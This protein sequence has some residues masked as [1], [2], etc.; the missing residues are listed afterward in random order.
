MTAARS[1]AAGA[2]LSPSPLSRSERP[3]RAAAAILLLLAGALLLAL[4]SGPAH[5]QTAQTVDNDWALIP[6]G[7]GPGE[8]FRLLFITSTTRAAN[9]ASIG[10]YNSFVQ[11]RADNGHSAIDSFSG[12]FRA[13]ISTP[14][15]DARD[16]TA[17]TGTGVPIY[18]LSGAKVADDYSDFYN[19]D[20][21]SNAAKSESGSGPGSNVVWTGSNSDGTGYDGQEARDVGSVGQ[22][23]WG[24]ADLHGSEISRDH[25]NGNVSYRLYGLSPVI[26]VSHNP[27]KTTGVTVDQI[28]HNSIQVT[29]IKPTAESSTRPI[30]SFGVDTRERNAADN[31][32]TDWTRRITPGAD[33]TSR[34]LQGLPSGTRQQVRVFARAH[35]PGQT[36]E[37]LFGDSDPVEFTT[38]A[39]AAPG[40]PDAPTVG[41][42]ADSTTSLDVS[43]TAPANTGPPITGYDLQ[44][45]A[46]N[47][48]GWTDGPQDV[49]ATS[50]AI[51]GLQAGTEYQVQVRASNAAGDGAW[52]AWRAGETT[53]DNHLPVFGAT[54]YTFTLA[55]NADGG[56]TAVAVGTVSA[57]DADAGHTVTYAIVA[58]NTAGNDFVIGSS[59]GAITYTGSGVNFEATASFTLTVRA[60]D[61]AGGDADVTVT[62][63]VTDDNTEAP[64]AP[65]APAFGTGTSTSIVATWTEPDNAGP[66]ITGYDVEYRRVTTP[67]SAWVDA[68]HSGTERTIAISGLLTGTGY[69]V[70]VRATNAEGTSGWSASGTGT[71]GANHAPEF[72]FP[73]GETSYAFDLA[74][75]ADGSGET[76]V[77]VGT[78]SATDAD[79]GHAV[80]YAIVAGNT[81]G[82]DFVIGSS[83]GAITYTGSGVNFE[84]TASFTLTVR[85]SDGAGGSADATVTVNVVDADE[86]PS[87]PAAPTFG[88]T[89]A[90]T[91]VVRWTE[92]ANT[93]PAITGYG[94][95]YRLAS[96]APDGTWTSRDAGTALRTTLR[97]LTEDERYQVQVRATNAEGE[98]A[99]STSSEVTVVGAPRVSSVGVG[100]A[101]DR[102][103]TYGAG[104]AII[105]TL[106]FTPKVTVTGT[107]RIALIV[108]AT[109]RYAAYA[110]T[111]DF[112]ERSLVNFRYTVEAGDRDVN[113]IGIPA[114]GL[115]LNG[116]AI[117]ARAG[118]AAA[119]LD[120]AAHAAGGGHK[121]DG[122]GAADRTA[123]GLGAA[124]VDGTTL[125]LAFDEA[126]DP[127]SVPGPSAFT[128]TVAGSSRTVNAVSVS[129]SRVTLTLASAV[130]HDQ[131]V[132]AGY[133]KPAADPLQDGTGNAVATFSGQVATNTT[134]SPTGPAITSFAFGADTTPEMGDTFGA[135]ETIEVVLQYEPRVNVTG[136]PRIALD[137]GGATRYA[138]FSSGDSHLTGFGE[139]SLLSFRYTVQ[140]GDRDEDGISVAANSLEL[141]GGTIVA[142]SGGA[143]A[144]RTHA[145]I[146]A[147]ATRKVDGGTLMPPLAPDLSGAEVQVDGQTLTF[148]WHPPA[149]DAARAAVTGYRVERSADG[150]APWTAITPNLAADANPVFSEQ[151]VP[152]G[153]TRHYRVFALS[154]AGDSPASASVTGTVPASGGD[155]GGGEPGTTPPSGGGSGT[156]PPSGGG[157]S[158]GGGS[159]SG[160]GGGSSATVRILHAEPV[161]EGLPARFRITL[162]APARRRLDLL[163]STTPGTASE[164]ADY[165]GLR[166]RPVT[167]A[168]GESALWLEVATRRDGEAED[169]ETFTV[170][171]SVAPGSAPARVV[172]HEA[173]G[174]IL[175]GPPPTAAVPLLLSASDPAGRQGFVRVVNHSNA[176]G[177]VTV[178]ALDDAG[179]DYGPVT[180]PIAARGSF[181]F[182]TNDLEGGNEAKGLTGSTGAGTGHWRLQLTSGVDIEA[183]AYARHAD[184]FLTALHDAARGTSARLATFNPGSNYRQVS[185]LRLS[186]RGS[187]PLAV[188]VT[189][190]DDAGSA[191]GGAVTVD[192][193]SSAAA[194]HAADALEA[195]TGA[196]TAGSLGDGDGKWRLR[197]GA[198]A[199]FTL[200]GFM[201]SP[202]GHLTNLTSAP[203]EPADG[204]VVVPL[205]LSAADPQGRQGFLRVVNRS[206]GAGTVRIQA[207]DDSGMAYEPLELALDAGAAVQFNADDLELGNAAKGLAG[208]TGP[209]HTGHWWLAVT[210]DLDYAVLAYARHSDG[211]LT[212]LHDAAPAWDGAHRVATFNPGSNWR[213]VSRLRLL[214]TGSEDLALRVRGIDDAGAPSA[215]TV[216]V[217]VPTRRS[218]TLDAAALEAGGEGFEGSLGDGA[219]KWRLVVE[220]DGGAGAL[221]AMSLMESPS[222]HLT[223]LSTRTAVRE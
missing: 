206:D 84:A 39:D 180:F 33:V 132:T 20:W 18:W 158:S 116:G 67:A 19:G 52:S 121:V 135:G 117:V 163:A 85:A 63:N 26:N 102:G 51:A 65:A 187:E 28:T 106:G 13:L 99:W 80:T 171:L 202:S 205:F 95:R 82:D 73:D 178:R 61:G 142:R 191:P 81:A 71:T 42:T 79:D 215:G 151:D 40:Q 220:A 87:A 11:D 7:L 89:T 21:D 76:A 201:E 55:E 14:S 165:E 130:S 27:G 110:A 107:A 77:A 122:G 192:L 16:N 161:V 221:R 186:H 94:V 144:R 200:M 56:T 44:Y 47:S 143:N 25:Q 38:F 207:H 193:P 216:S 29:W 53:T 185:R 149:A 12:E 104:E 156:P 162:D 36:P 138:A 183:L 139:R 136:T 90:T 64:A 54:D 181:H 113:G 222:G 15:T 203:L 198:D 209:A 190:T 141:N 30:T 160:G 133:T 105:V 2:P 197:A 172:R 129:G 188:R 168:P 23:R 101:P 157:G 60:S 24:R 1:R 155:D 68:M 83:N 125:T 167:V 153:T 211:F 98:G 219:G 96:S 223:N 103:D 93:G 179:A 75:N 57:T 214:N 127:D 120:H 91:A 170:T 8:S 45:R 195:G 35:Q 140:A 148:R 146:A 126:L 213:Q 100:G 66:D 147:D 194:S 175:N 9:S 37:T 208:A 50:T 111:A 43:W 58:G 176:A 119:V 115:E 74:E 114:N 210:S 182:N 164:G 109:R 59:S 88:A 173:R 108:G 204:K 48:G 159:G 62:V 123:P 118:G 3:R 137:I 196:G 72:T 169:D 41:P 32:W 212:S 128:V 199:P 218:V 97:G 70:R 69:E 5:A 34:T 189:G 46:G 49:P 174:T 17:T 166:R 145:A 4:P 184:G 154:A 112:G 10:D 31:G 177:E 217:T 86:P 22:V 6:S 78:V 124:T 152:R 134:P 150:N 131:A 92:P